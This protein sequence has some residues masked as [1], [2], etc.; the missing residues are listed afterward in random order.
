M[1][2]LLKVLSSRG[3][4][5]G[6]GELLTTVTTLSC[7]GVLVLKG[8]NFT[9]GNTFSGRDEDPGRLHH[10]HNYSDATNDLLGMALHGSTLSVSVTLVNYHSVRIATTQ[11][12]MFCLPAVITNATLL[13]AT[14]TTR[15]RI[16][17][18]RWVRS[19]HVG[20]EY[21]C[22]LKQ[23]ESDNKYFFLSR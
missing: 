5:E 8:R 20:L 2:Q 11:P 19:S 18:T 3:V 1:E 17:H 9:L 23:H 12:L 16:S 7:Q 15:P 10:V 4:C 6:T 14:R 22:F 21:I 13:T